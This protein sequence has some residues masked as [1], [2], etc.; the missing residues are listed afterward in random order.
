MMSIEYGYLIAQCSLPRRRKYDDFRRLPGAVF[1][2][3]YSSNMQLQ[4]PGLTINIDIERQQSF[5]QACAF[6]HT[7]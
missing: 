6:E 2:Y 4:P 7:V 5:K 1:G 3:S